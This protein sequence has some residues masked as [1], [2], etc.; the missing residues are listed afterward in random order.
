M[1][2]VKSVISTLVCR[3][4]VCR[5][6]L[7]AD[8]RSKNCTCC[9]PLSIQEAAEKAAQQEPDHIPETLNWEKSPGG[10]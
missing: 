8:C 4:Q 10:F 5:H 2:Q 9:C 6:L 1:E 3:C 7:R